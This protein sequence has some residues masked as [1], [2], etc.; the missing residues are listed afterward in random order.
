MLQVRTKATLPTLP[1]E[2]CALEPIMSRDIM[3]VHHAKHHNTYV[4]NYNNTLEKFQTAV[5]KGRVILN[6]FINLLY[7]FISKYVICNFYR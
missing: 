4:I 1:F 3:E 2:Y 6:N 7:L 5:A